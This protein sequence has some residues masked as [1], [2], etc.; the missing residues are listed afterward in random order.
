MKTQRGFSLIETLIVVGVVG[1]IGVL[2]A[3]AVNTARA[4]QRDAVRVSH[5][6]QIQ[7][8]LEDFFNG[9]SAYPAGAGIPLGDSAQSACLGPGGF[10]ASCGSDHPSFLILGTYEPGLK[11]LATCG[12][13]ERNAF[14]YAQA[15]EGVS[16]G[17]QFELERALPEAGLQ[18]GVNCA[19]PETM[20]AGACK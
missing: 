20:S 4:R 15:A 1:I 5:V 8:A 9:H 14:C 7:S 13:P 16:Y 2:A 18:K 17:I 11:G 12:T 6:R 3:V 10:V 19:T